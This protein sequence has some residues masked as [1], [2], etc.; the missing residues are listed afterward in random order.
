MAPL[1]HPNH[2]LFAGEKPSPGE[3]RDPS[4]RRHFWELVQPTNLTRAKLPAEAASHW[5]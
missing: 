5:F 4:T 3:L 2:A 1:I